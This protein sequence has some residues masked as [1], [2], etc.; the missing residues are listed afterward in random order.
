MNTSESGFSKKT[1]VAQDSP[2]RDKKNPDDYPPIGN[3]DVVRTEA[4][5]CLESAW[6]DLPKEKLSQIWTQ[7]TSEGFM[8][9]QQASSFCDVKTESPNVFVVV[10]PAER[11]LQRDFCEK[12]RDAINA[13]IAK[14]LGSSTVLRLV[15]DANASI[16]SCKSSPLKH[17]R[18]ADSTNK[19]PVKSSDYQ[20][21]RQLI[22][23][24][25]VAREI[26]N[27]FAAELSEIKPPMK[28]TSRWGSADE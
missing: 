24:S 14:Q 12:E 9:P 27:I 1:S 21:L 20:T 5:A 28:K 4:G 16:A 23:K 3:A 10:F 6:L 13:R 15:L 11:Q 8:L 25:E 7:A 22:E 19:R 18:N 17:N 26:Q 2:T